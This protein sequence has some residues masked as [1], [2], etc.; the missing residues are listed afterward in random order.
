MDYAWDRHLDLEGK[1]VKVLGSGHQVL[2]SCQ[3]PG[4]SFPWLQIVHHS[5]NIRAARVLPIIVPEDTVAAEDATCLE[6]IHSVGP[7]RCSVLFVHEKR[8]YPALVKG[9]PGDTLC[10]MPG[11]VIEGSD[12]SIEGGAMREFF[13]EVGADESGV[14]AKMPLILEP[15]PA[16]AGA[17]IEGHSLYCIV[18]RA[19][20]DFCPNVDEP[21]S[22]LSVVPLSNSYRWLTIRHELGEECTELKT[23]LALLMLQQE[24]FDLYGSTLF[25]RRW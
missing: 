16:S 18:Y 2:F 8:P 19:Q 6:I 22:K 23:L 3:Q 7:E 4:V 5:G 20:K 17:Q 14:L 9:A 21:I 24:Y 11:G 10:E 1:D 15:A 12:V 25:H 13:E